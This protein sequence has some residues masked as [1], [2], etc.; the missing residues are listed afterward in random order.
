[1]DFLTPRLAGGEFGGDVVVS[2][3]EIRNVSPGAHR[4]EIQFRNAG[5]TGTVKMGRRT[6][7]LQYARE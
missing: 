3:C 7:M 6:T 1:V 4:V 2:F 5:A